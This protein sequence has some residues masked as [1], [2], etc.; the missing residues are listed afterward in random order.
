[1]RRAAL[2]APRTFIWHIELPRSFSTAA[3]GNDWADLFA[4]IV[5]R[6]RCADKEART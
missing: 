5:A 4:A 1:M 3:L 6:R 2:A